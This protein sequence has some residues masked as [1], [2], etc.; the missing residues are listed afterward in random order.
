MPQAL[1]VDDEPTSVSAMAELVEKEGF[2]T[3]TAGTLA[4]AKATV[5]HLAGRGWRPP[6]PRRE[7][8]VAG[9]PGIAEFSV[10]LRQFQ[11]AG[12]LSDYDVHVRKK[13]AY[14]LC[15]GDIDQEFPVSEEYLLGLEREVFLS[16]CGEEKTLERIAHTLKTGKPL[17]N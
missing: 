2:T 16:L 10:I 11:A 13:F 8:R 1:I 3:T 9:R 15:G 14:A 6:R 17:R 4:D 7:V 12:Y 5:I